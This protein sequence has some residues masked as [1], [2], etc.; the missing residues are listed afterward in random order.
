L[1]SPWFFNRADGVVVLILLLFAVAFH[2]RVL[3]TPDHQIPWDL[4]FDHWPTAQF[5]ADEL[6]FGKMPLWDPWT[7]CGRPIY[8]NIQAQL[9]Y[10]PKLIALYT[11]VF[12]SRWSLLDIL[13]W[14]VVLHIWFGATGLYRLSRILDNRVRPSLFAGVIAIGGAF[15]ASQ[16]QH[17]GI[18][19][20]S[21]WLPWAWLAVVRSRQR[22]WLSNIVYTSV[23]VAMGLLAGAPASVLVMWISMMMLALGMR[24]N[25]RQSGSLLAGIALGAF[26]S[27]VQLWPTWELTTNSVAKFRADYL[28][29]N[30]GIPW[31][32]LVSLV[33]PDWFGA[34]TLQGYSLPYN[35][36]WLYLFCGWTGLIAALYGIWHR[37]KWAAFLWMLTAL[38]FGILNCVPLPEAFRI[39]FYP[40]FVGAA[41]TLGFALVAG[42]GLQQIAASY[43]RLGRFQP[44]LLGCLVLELWW[45][46][47][48]RPMNSVAVKD[49]PGVTR[50]SFFG[51]SGILSD[52]RKVT[53]ATNSRLDTIEDSISW[54][55]SAPLLQLRNT[56]GCD[57][58]APERLIRARLAFARG[59]RWGR[60]YEV[61]APLTPALDA[62]S[63]RYLLTKKP[64]PGI[65]PSYEIDGHWVYENTDALPR[66]YFA[67]RVVGTRNLEDSAARFTQLGFDPHVATLI[68]GVADENSNGL[69]S[70]TLTSANGGLPQG[71]QVIEDQPNSIQLTT[72]LP[73]AGWLVIADTNYPGW[74]AAVNGK[75][76]PIHHANVA[77]RAVRLPAGKAT[78][79][80]LFQ[81]SAL[82]L[83]AFVSATF[84]VVWIVG[85]LIL[86]KRRIQP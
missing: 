1:R 79:R 53:R 34:L 29:H 40:E 31:Q 64:F 14:M 20:V 35:F 33:W 28:T 49:D 2:W 32:S 82:M 6:A 59:A 80:L 86:V 85:A 30:P 58:F 25:F 69:P 84:A 45:M 16:V 37:R 51:K 24:L 5:L 71:L 54:S 72:Q 61:A 74:V 18:I 7:Y 4:R 38:M 23:P 57:P 77:F 41:F 56:N 63:A 81:P 68:E 10:P 26:L 46:G 43:P 13:E 60:W 73:Q 22:D 15:F 39:A 55:M 3:L 27:A 12:I 70:P 52:L 62:F 11:H 76:A 65:I 50:Q 17:L 67:N 9:F 42:F 66:F 21:S 47:A 78:V 8:A 36:T 83:G 19:C 44:I 75:P 48:S